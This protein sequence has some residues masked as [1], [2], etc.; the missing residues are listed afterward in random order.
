MPQSFRAL[1][2]TN[3]KR[4]LGA[5]DKYLVTGKLPVPGL[6]GPGLSLETV[7]PQDRA[8]RVH[9][10]QTPGQGMWPVSPSF[11]F[12]K[13]CGVVFG[14]DARRGFACGELIIPITRDNQCWALFLEANARWAGGILNRQS[15]YIVRITQSLVEEGEKKFNRKNTKP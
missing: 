5:E 6:P 3:G 11:L 10:E 1:Y 8:L 14:R 4:T 15:Y 2:L 13:D 7:F 12:T 9:P